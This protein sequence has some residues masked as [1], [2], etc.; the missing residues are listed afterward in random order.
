M[1]REFRFPVMQAIRR[2]AH[3]P[4]DAECMARFLV[5]QMILVCAAHAAQKTWI[6]GQ[7]ACTDPDHDAV[8]EELIASRPSGTMGEDQDCQDC[9]GIPR[10]AL[11]D[12][13]VVA[14]GEFSK[15]HRARTRFF[16]PGH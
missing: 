10:P 2:I 13:I 1:P 12:Y 8:P 4:K 15:P 5:M 9:P 7:A 16:L 3:T 11:W 6:T 14:S